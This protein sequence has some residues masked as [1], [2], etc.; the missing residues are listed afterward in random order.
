LEVSKHFW[1]E[2]VVQVKQN[3]LLAQVSGGHEEQSGGQEK[4]GQIV[5][6]F[7]LIKLQR[8]HFELEPALLESIQPGSR[9]VRVQTWTSQRE[10]I[11]RGSLL[12]DNP[13]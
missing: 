7:E 4:E 6:P 2:K 12:K 3:A 8:V 10:F 5:K 9:L 11:F 1:A 13:F